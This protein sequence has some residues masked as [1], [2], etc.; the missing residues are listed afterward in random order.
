MNTKALWIVLI[1]IVLGIVAW[2]AFAN[3]A[4]APSTEETSG[5]PIATST[6]NVATSTVVTVTYGSTGFSPSSINVAVGDTVRFVNQSGTDMWV[7]VDD[8]PTHME[9]DG[10][11]LRDHCPTT[12]VFDQCT[13]GASGSSYEFTFT[14]AGVFGYHNHMRATDTGAVTVR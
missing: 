3:K 6:P 9:Y 4:T 7:A 12:T 11:A 1:V 2:L 5:T 14:K 8:H 10:T 13:R